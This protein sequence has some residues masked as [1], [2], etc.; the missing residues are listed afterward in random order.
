MD[1]NTLAEQ[2]T[3]H[4][5]SQAERPTWPDPNWAS[6]P[7][8]DVPMPSF[9]TWIPP[10]PGRTMVRHVFRDLTFRCYYL[11]VRFILTI[12]LS[13][14]LRWAPRI[15]RV[16]FVF[17]KKQ[18]RM[19]WANIEHC[20]SH[21]DYPK[22][23]R[24]VYNHFVEN[25]SLSAVESIYMSRW[26]E[27]VETIKV[28][29]D[30]I[31]RLND[32]MAQGR[33]LVLITAH[34]GSWEFSAGYL[35]QMGYPIYPIARKQRDPRFE[36]WL[37]DVRANV[38]LRILYRGESPRE[39]LRILRRGHV[40]AILGDLDTRSGKGIFV[41]FLGRPAYTQT[42]PYALARRAG[43]PVMMGLCYR[44]ADRRLRFH[45]SDWWNVPT[46]DDAEK[47]I[48]TATIRISQYLEKAVCEHPEQWLWNHRRW[49]TK[50]TD[51]Q[52]EG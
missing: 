19:I 32:A 41:D 50:P 22:S 42:G 45:F 17:L 36:Q 7:Q 13:R 49:K 34:F 18:R 51:L 39:M 14:A 16:V 1:N 15:G 33:G 12:G 48:E 2:P 8:R 35:A 44:E 28:E 20:L 30:G 3:N 5:E 25:L 29:F 4:Q 26:P 24:D 47:D 27:L 11:L 21:C 46:T 6:P 52:Q 37:T 31:E 23:T 43:A 9:W 10:L 38:G 40:V